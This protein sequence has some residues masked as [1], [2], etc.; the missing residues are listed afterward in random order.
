MGNAVTKIDDLYFTLYEFNNYYIS[1]YNQSEDF[2]LVIS[3]NEE[4]V[5]YEVSLRND[6]YFELYGLNQCYNS[7]SKIEEI[8]SKINSQNKKFLIVAYKNKSSKL[9]IKNSLL[10]RDTV[11]GKDIKD[12]I[13]SM[14][15]ISSYEYGGDLNKK[16]IFFPGLSIQNKIHKF[17]IY[18]D[19]CLI[20]DSQRQKMFDFYKHSKYKLIRID[21]NP[22]II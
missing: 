3:Y 16:Y 15:S 9:I 7:L 1:S 10:K 2:P 11:S 21:N 14:G 13:Y 18:E 12:F 19:D 6:N 17:L 20:Y 5:N 4:K 22:K 8:E